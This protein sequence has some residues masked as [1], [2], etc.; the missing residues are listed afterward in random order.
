[1]V[2]SHTFQNIRWKKPGFNL[3]GCENLSDNNVCSTKDENFLEA[4][5]SDF[6]KSDPTIHS[7]LAKFQFMWP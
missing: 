4:F 5:K 3:C 7:G 1:M 6:K 2:P